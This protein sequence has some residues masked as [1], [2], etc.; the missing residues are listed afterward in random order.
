MSHGSLLRY[1][2]SLFSGT[3]PCLCL[4]PATSVT[5]PCNAPSDKIAA[6]KAFAI[7][8]CKYIINTHNRLVYTLFRNIAAASAS[9]ASFFRYKGT[10]FFRHGQEKNRSFYFVKGP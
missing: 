5:L 1:S 3:H 7:G 8:S 10:I 6:F 2:Y 4:Q 9:K